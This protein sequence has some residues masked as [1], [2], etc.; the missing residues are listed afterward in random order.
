MGSFGEG[1]RWH[2]ELLQTYEGWRAQESVR[3]IEPF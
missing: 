1:Q 2:K 3:E